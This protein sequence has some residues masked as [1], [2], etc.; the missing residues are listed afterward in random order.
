MYKKSRVIVLA[1]V[2]LFIVL[3]FNVGYK[4]AGY[5]DSRELHVVYA[6]MI[7]DHISEVNL[8]LDRIDG[9]G[10]VEKIRYD[11]NKSVLDDIGCSVWLDGLKQTSSDELKSFISGVGEAFSEVGNVE[12]KCISKLKKWGPTKK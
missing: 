11:F 6:N 7:G 9:S 10:N 3:S 12:S 4:Y 2:C 8:L 1:V 5:L